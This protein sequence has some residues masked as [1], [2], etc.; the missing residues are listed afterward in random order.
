MASSNL[1]LLRWARL[2]GHGER[3]R[4]RIQLVATSSSS[5]RSTA[6]ATSPIPARGAYSELSG[7]GSETVTGCRPARRTLTSTTPQGASTVVCPDANDLHPRRRDHRT[8]SNFPEVYVVGA[9]DG[10][11]SVTLDASG[12]TFVSSPQFSYV[13]ARPTARISCWAPIYA[14]ERHGPGRGLERQGRVLQLYQ[15]ISSAP[16]QAPVRSRAR[17]ANVVGSSE[18]FVSQAL[19]FNAASVFESGSGTDMCRPDKSRQRQLVQ[20]RHGQPLSVGF[21]TITVN[22]L[23]RVHAEQTLC[24]SRPRSW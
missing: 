24:P 8:L 4:W 13:T 3:E 18:Q 10:T 6:T 12:G 11:D 7:F 16:R 5:I 19:S 21:S 9:K 17:L 23:L 20:H 22:S 14:A 15:P 1:Y 2:F